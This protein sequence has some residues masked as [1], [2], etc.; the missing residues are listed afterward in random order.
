MLGQLTEK[1]INELMAGQVT[2]RLGCVVNQ[3]A[4]IV[5]INYFYKDSTI[6]SHSAPGKKIEM[7]RKNPN[8]CFQIDQISSIFRWQSAI[9]W[10]TYEE[11][12]DPEKKGILYN[13]R[14]QTIS[15]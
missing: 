2:G 9:L 7:M 10:G 11:I 3:K 1:Q 14:Y 4:Y 5:P 12:T 13:A 15:R 6:Y 8:V